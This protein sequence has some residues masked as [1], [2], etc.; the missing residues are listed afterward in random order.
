MSEITNKNEIRQAT[1]KNG[2]ILG[3]FALISTGLIAVTHMITKDKIAEEIEAAMARRLNEIIPANQYDNDVYHDCALVMDSDLLGTEEE[4]KVYRM[5]NQENDYALFMTSVAP[6]GYAG[7]IKLVIGIYHNGEIAGVR[8]TEHQETPGLGD[9]I[10]IEKSDW[11]KQFNGRSLE[12]TTAE[13]WK[14][15]KDGGE[16]DA[17]TGAT[18][19]PRAIVK[20]V[21]QTLQY[22]TQNTEFLFDQNSECGE[23]Q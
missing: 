17:L 14:V 15:A 1:F 13:Q 7:K 8:V 6:D 16:F 23:S 20:S 11:I 2:A 5:R 22:Y 21:Y 18:I 10:E 9:K 3:L 12:N 19:T 4:L